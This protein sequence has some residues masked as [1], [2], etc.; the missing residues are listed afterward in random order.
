MS[1][2]EHVGCLEIAG[3]RRRIGLLLQVHDARHR[4]DDVMER[5]LMTERPALAEA[6][7]RA[8]DE[9][10]LHRRQRGVVAAELRDDARKEIL[11]DDVGGARE[12]QH[13]LAGFGMREIERQARLAR[14]DPDEVRGLIGPAGF[15]LRVAASRV[16]A[17]ARAL[18]LDHA[19][20]QIGEQP[21]AVRAGQHAREVENGETG[22][23]RVVR[24]G[25]GWSPARGF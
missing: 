16:V 9:L 6:G 5:R 21:C 22:E 4:V 19:R 23:K 14:V 1:A 10:G 7:D 2:G 25:H 20:A 13:D 18:D 12:I 11:D 3:P 17:F 8:V 24:A 15:H